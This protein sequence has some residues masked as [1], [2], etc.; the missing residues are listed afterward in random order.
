MRFATPVLVSLAS[1]PALVSAHDILN[2]ARHVEHA[3][4]AATPAAAAAAATTSAAA[5]AA[6]STTYS[7]F[8]PVSVS[9][10][11]TNPTAIPLSSIIAGAPTQATHAINKPATP[12]S[13]PTTIP[14][15][16]PVPNGEFSLLS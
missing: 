15:A 4:Q 6:S 13:A 1:L 12:G 11:S 10:Q 3:R 7:S 16:P 8:P 2:N 14:S 5:A 9:L